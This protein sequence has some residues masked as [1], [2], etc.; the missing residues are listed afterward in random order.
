MGRLGAG[1]GGWGSRGGAMAGQQRFPQTLHGFIFQ[2]PNSDSALWV[3]GDL[4]YGEGVVG[5]SK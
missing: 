4:V 2:T 3:R 5:I 1:W